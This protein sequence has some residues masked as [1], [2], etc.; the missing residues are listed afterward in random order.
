MLEEFV[1][2]INKTKYIQG[3][4]RCVLCGDLVDRGPQTAEVIEYAI[5]IGAELV[6][7]NHDDKYIQYKKRYIDKTADIPVVFSDSQQKIWDSLNDEHLKYLENGKYC[8]ELPEYNAVVVHAGVIPSNKKLTDRPRIEYLLTRYIDKNTHERTRLPNDFSK[9]KNSVHWTDLYEG[10]IDIVYG[11][12]VYSFNKPAI[13][14]SKRGGRTIGIDTGAVYGGNLTALVYNSDG[15]EE[16]IQVK[17]R[18]AWKGF[19]LTNPSR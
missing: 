18:E 12:D 17:S 5:S 3:V 7:G 2:L 4:D 11:H 16:F 15:T 19:V 6:I 14:I 9:P 1:Q 10:V 8:L 13:R